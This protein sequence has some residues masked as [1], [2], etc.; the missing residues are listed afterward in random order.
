[1][2]FEPLRLCIIHDNARG[3]CGRVVPLMKEML[4]ER[5]F[6][7]DVHEIS[8]GSLDLAPYAGLVIGTP[9]FGLG[10]RSV[11]PTPALRSFIEDLPDLEDHKVA[12]FCVYETRPGRTFDRMKNLLFDKGAD[13]VAEHAYWFLQPRRHAHIIPA[14]CM[15]RIR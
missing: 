15:I 11:G 3:H 12:V 1:M 14:E 13:F 6:E 5:A 2:P 7:V 4:E 10:I 8:Q 9:V